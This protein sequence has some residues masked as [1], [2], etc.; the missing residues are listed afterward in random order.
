RAVRTAD[1]LEVLGLGIALP[2][3]TAPTAAAS[4]A[5]PPSD[6][7]HQPDA[8]QPAEATAQGTA[9][10]AAPPPPEIRIEKF[11]VHGLDFEYR[12]RTVEPTFVVPLNGL[13]VAV[14]GFSTRA[15]TEPATIRFSAAVTGGEVPLPKVVESGSIVTGIL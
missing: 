5:A 6:G 10:D 12:D 4:G 8:A 13:D 15:A 2:Q 9:R 14:S 1:G 3:A 7:A 11:G